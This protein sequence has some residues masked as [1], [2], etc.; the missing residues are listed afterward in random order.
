MS[1]IT[2]LSPAR[3]VAGRDI[4][5]AGIYDIDASHST[6]EF[7]ARFLR[8]TKV[9]GRFTAFH[10]AIEVADDPLASHVELEIDAAS[11]DSHDDKR[12]AHL[13][14]ADFL[15]VEHHSALRYRSTRVEPHGDRWRVTGDLTIRGVTQPVTLDVTFEGVELDP[16]GGH[17]LAVSA[18]GE[19]DRE[20]WGL[21]WNQALETGGVL[22]GKTVAIELEV[23]AVGQG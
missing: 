9:R 19:I 23:S 15:D 21:T 4:P 7:V 6:V 14:S 5:P 16:D 17:R 20:Q 10:G 3:S 2:S 18:R 1:Q 12:D 22:V 8:V 11:I 13:R